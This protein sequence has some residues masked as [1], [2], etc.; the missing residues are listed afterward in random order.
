MLFEENTHKS[1]SFG[2]DSVSL[3]SFRS[4]HTPGSSL[5]TCSV[6]VRALALEA[7][8]TGPQC[9]YFPLGPRG[10]SCW[11]ILSGQDTAG[12]IQVVWKICV[13]SVSS[14]EMCS[15]RA[16]ALVSLKLLVG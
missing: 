6:S 14:L 1:K 4:D 15:V 8:T 9:T 10:L 2:G 3:V 12:V 11:N 7:S 5:G 13:A 16:T